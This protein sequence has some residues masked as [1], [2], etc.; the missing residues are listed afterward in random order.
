MAS[1]TV[2]PKYQV[3]IPKQVRQDMKLKAGETL[4]VLFDQGTIR[5]LRV[6]PIRALRGFAK[7]MPPFEREKK[8]RE[9]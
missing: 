9:F 7:G 1:V 4:E 6:P 2:S 3:V 5:L 8:D